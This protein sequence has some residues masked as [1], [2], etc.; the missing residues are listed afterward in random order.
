MYMLDVYWMNEEFR[1]GSDI[2][3]HVIRPLLKT[4]SHPT[5][6]S[7]I[8]DTIVVFQPDRIPSLF[9][10]ATFPLTTLLET[11]WEMYSNTLVGGAVI[12]PCIIEFTSMVKQAL[13]FS[14]TGNE[15]WPVDQDMWCP[16]TSSRRTQELTYSKEHYEVYFNDVKHLVY[17]KVLH[18][19]EP[20]LKGNKPISFFVDNVIK[21]STNNLPRRQPPFIAGGNFLA[22][23]RIA[24]EEMKRCVGWDSIQGKDVDSF[25]SEAIS[26][27]CES[28]KINH[29]PW[30]ANPTLDRGNH[31]STIVHNVWLNLGA[32]G[33]PKPALSV[34]FITRRESI[35]VAALN[36]SAQVQLSDSHGDWSA[37][38]KGMNAE[39]LKEKGTSMGCKHQFGTDAA[40]RK[41]HWQR[42]PPRAPEAGGWIPYHGGMKLPGALKLLHTNLTQSNQSLQI[43]SDIMT[44]YIENMTVQSSNREWTIEQ[45]Y[46]Q[47][48]EEQGEVE[49]ELAHKV[50]VELAHEVEMKLV[51][52]VRLELTCEVEAELACKVELELVCE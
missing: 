2:Y 8:K 21:Q 27:I 29:I 17:A 19:I 37:R 1:N 18:E 31:S 32:T 22:V 34:S 51:H 5:V 28:L 15:L 50:E 4:W 42:P 16:L 9:A 36:S 7:P 26:H 25:I 13:N 35:Q 12:N 44:H 3:D 11:I 24:I 45:E 46:E 10:C 23:M 40:V 30:M 47:S 33:A 20:A 39:N 43:H 38:M 41:E 49:L 6:L 48:V 14:H 52:E